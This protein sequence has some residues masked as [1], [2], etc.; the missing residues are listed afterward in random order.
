MLG[1][2]I[3]VDGGSA[4]LP[5][6]LRAW[7]AARGARLSDVVELRSMLF[8][9]NGEREL[10]DVKA[11]DPAY[12][13]VGAVALDPPAPLAAALRGSGHHA[14]SA[15]PAAARHQARRDRA[16]RQCLV[17]RARRDHRRAGPGGDAGPARP[18]GDDRARCRAG[19]RADPAG[20]ARRAP[21]AR[22]A[23]AGVA[24]RAPSSPRCAAAFP[25]PAGAC[26]TR[27]RPRPAC[28]ASSTR[29]AC[30]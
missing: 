8:A 27:A 16:A 28:S 23:A 24:T 4:P 25:I 17:H 19:D 20:L 7:L 14:R 29:P 30:S 6:A 12:P 10:V 11:V 5:D 3:E 22:H 18:A 13:L 15:D 21:A 2:D 9:T 26:A 1:G